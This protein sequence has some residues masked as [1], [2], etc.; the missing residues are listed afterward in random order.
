[1]ARIRRV[2]KLRNE[3]EAAEEHRGELEEVYADLCVGPSEPEKT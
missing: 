2:V 1:M 3:V